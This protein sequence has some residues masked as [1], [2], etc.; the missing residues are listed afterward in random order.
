MCT[1]CGQRR[2][3]VHVSRIV[4]GQKSEA[5]LCDECAAEQGQWQD[6]LEPQFFINEVLASLLPVPGR[7]GQRPEAGEPVCP[8]CGLTYREFSRRGLLGCGECY[9]AFGQVLP[10]VLR[11]VHGNI[12]HEGKVPAHLE[13][14]Q[15][16]RR[17]MNRLRAKL[18][19]AVS[20]ERYEEAAQLRD[21]LRSLERSSA[22]E[23]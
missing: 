16:A 1:E 12:R 14:W 11:R 18:E 3:T 15:A 19:E 13:A 6:F 20:N 10:P 7:V 8:A 2:A 5:R 21:E 4:N 9:D 22:G 23:E 17:E